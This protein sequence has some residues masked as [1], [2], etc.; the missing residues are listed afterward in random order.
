[1]SGYDLSEVIG[2]TPGSVLQGAGTDANTVAQIRKAIA[3][4]QTIRTELLNYA[5]DGTAYWID[6]TITPVH[7]SSGSLTHFMSI[8]RD[9]TH[10]KEL[11]R[12]TEAALLKER[13]RRRERKVLSQMSEWLFAAKSMEELQ[14]VVTRSMSRLFP[15]TDGALFIYSNSR[16]V[17]DQASFWGAP[18]GDPHLQADQCWG[19]RRARN[20][21]F[22]T[23]EIDF[24]CGHVASD[25]HPY[26]CLPII[27]HGDIIGLMH[28]SFPELTVNRDDADAM[29]NRLLS[30]FEV[31][32]ICAEQIS[33]AAANVRLHAEL[34]NK[35]V[36]DALTGLWN[37]RWF[38]DMAGREIRRAEVRGT[39]LS[40][41]M[42]DADHFKKFNDAHGHDAG[43][44]VLKVLGSHLS[45]LNTDGMF[46]CRI[47]GE[48]F[49]VIC[50]GVDA[51]TAEE[52]MTTLRSHLSEAQIVY[53]GKALPRVT[54]SV[55]VAQL[56]SGETL[57]SLMKR[58]DD[59]LYAAKDAGRD[60]VL[61]AEQD[62]GSKAAPDQYSSS[63]GG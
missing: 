16:D 46:P 1:M 14:D 51:V 18:P 44:T 6:L 47:G 22:G 54:I 26:F 25:V 7:D 56:G 59:A 4:R 58:A 49:A 5:K 19:L 17:L 3:A 40:L 27:A 28:L 43:D 38:L 36:K 15:R 41:A 61:R 39:P 42:I 23:S 11:M 53:S 12:Q 35:S 21:S 32:Q 31:A 50:A 48:E 57:Q 24:A 9:I 13:E 29:Q 60:C 20:Y 52:A 8:E 62:S 34:Q 33:L 63:G 45:D 2:R 10:S 30:M 37:R 55:G